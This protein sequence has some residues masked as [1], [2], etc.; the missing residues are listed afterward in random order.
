[1]QEFYR[2][3][4]FAFVLVLLADALLAAV[5]VERSYLSQSLLPR[6]VDDGRVVRWRHALTSIPWN[7]RFIHVDEGVRDGLR[8]DTNLP[9]DASVVSVSADLLAVDGKDRPA[10][11]DLSPYGTRFLS[12]C[13]LFVLRS[14]TNPT[15]IIGLNT[16]LINIP[17]I[18]I[19]VV[20]QTNI[21][22]SR[23]YWA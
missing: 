6:H 18:N 15:A 21:L 1:M 20:E 8:F 11:A 4:L 17:H 10:L 12:R 16:G 7:T 3:A 19:A 13:I 23:P 5:C 14:L 2:K 22:T 9:T